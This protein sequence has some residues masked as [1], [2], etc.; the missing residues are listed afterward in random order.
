MRELLRSDFRQ[1][2]EK[3]DVIFSPTTPG[4][5]FKLGAKTDDPLRMYLEDIYTVT[6][7]LV[8][9]P[10]L[11]FPMGTV[12]EDGQALPIGGQLMG[13]WFDEATVLNVAYALEQAK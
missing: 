3:V 12:T 5:A 6:A 1:A 13:R 2:F 9:V 11:S 4:P 8:G 10:A 7:N